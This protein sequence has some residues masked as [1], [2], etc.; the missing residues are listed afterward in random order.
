MTSTRQ[1]TL[2]FS[3]AIKRFPLESAATA[4]GATSKLEVASALLVGN[5]KE[6]GTP[7]YVEMIP[8]DKMTRRTMP[9]PMSAI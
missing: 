4:T 2:L 5:P 1:T 3:S 9:L 6:P 8:V 7:A